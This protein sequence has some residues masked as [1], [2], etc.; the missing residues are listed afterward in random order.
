[1]LTS[2]LALRVVIC[3]RVVARFVMHGCQR[4]ARI[5]TPPLLSSVLAHGHILFYMCIVRERER[6]RVCMCVPPIASG[7]VV[8]FGVACW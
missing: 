7:D 4:T 2:P 8:A 5:A 1:M 3:A 6:E